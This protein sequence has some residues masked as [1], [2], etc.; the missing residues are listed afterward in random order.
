[1][2][3]KPKHK[4]KNKENH[5]WPNNQHKH[6]KENKIFKIKRKYNKKNKKKLE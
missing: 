5:L 1:M 6:K 3:I 2:E 4:L